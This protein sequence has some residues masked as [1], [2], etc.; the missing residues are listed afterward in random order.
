MAP[1]YELI[2]LA[3]MIKQCWKTIRNLSK[4]SYCSDFASFEPLPNVIRDMLC[5]LL[6]LQDITT[7]Y[8]RLSTRKIFI[9]RVELSR[10]SGFK[11]SLY[12]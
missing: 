12:V 9:Q 1:S 5:S 2:A 11:N 6:I 4:P 7:A 8:K 3:P 10:Y